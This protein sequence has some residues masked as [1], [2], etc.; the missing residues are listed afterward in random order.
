MTKK[1]SS[2]LFRPF[3]QVDSSTTRKYGGT[4]LGLYISKKLATALN[5]K[6][7]VKSEKAI[8]TEF[9]VI[10]PMQVGKMENAQREDKM[11]RE[12]MILT[13]ELYPHKI[14][15][16]EDN[17]VNQRLAKI[18]L[19]KM[20][21]DCDIAGDG[22]EALEAFERMEEAKKPFYSIV[23][24]DMQMPQMDGLEATERLIE[25]YKEKCPPIVAMT[26]NVFIEDKEKCAK[27][28]MSDFLPKPIKQSELRQILIKYSN[29]VQK[30]AG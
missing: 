15:L 26:A 7:K 22:K 25:R 1:E 28:G 19:Q 9:T 14:L 16:V 17:S 23:F 18:M 2:K 20:G 11:K 29:K 10:L 21:Y 6:I 24:M 5:G 3:S 4:G 30:L 27:A 12:E 13:G 8:G